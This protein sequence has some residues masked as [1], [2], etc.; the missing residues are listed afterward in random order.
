MKIVKGIFV[1]TMIALGIVVLLSLIL[2][3][4]MFMFPKFK[5][6]GYGFVYQ[7]QATTQYA[8]DTTTSGAYNLRKY[9]D[10]DKIEINVTCDTG[11]GVTIQPVESYDGNLKIVRTDDYYG[12][13]KGETNKPTVTISEPQKTG[14]VLTLDIA[15][16]TPNGGIIYNENCGITIY[17]PVFSTT[18]T[19]ECNNDTAYTYNLDLQT[20]TGNII[21]R[22]ANLNELTTYFYPLK[23]DSLNLSSTKGDITVSGITK[24]ITYSPIES[25]RKTGTNEVTLS[26][27]DVNTKGGNVYFTDVPKLI[28]QNGISLTTNNGD[29]NFADLEVT[30][31]DFSLTN[32]N[33]DIGLVANNITICNGSFEYKSESGL[34]KITGTLTLGIADEECSIYTSTA[35][36]KIG[37]VTGGVL[38][39]LNEYGVVEITTD[40][41]ASTKIDSTHGNVSVASC[42]NA[43]TII[44]D[45]ADINATYSSSAVVQTNRG[46]VTLT[47]N[48]TAGTDGTD[49]TINGKTVVSSV[50]GDINLT[51]LNNPFQ[52]TTTGSSNVTIN[53]KAVSV[54][55]ASS[56]TSSVNLRSGKLTFKVAESITYQYALLATGTISGN[57]GATTNF[58]SGVTKIMNNTDEEKYEIFNLTASKIVFANI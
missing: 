34:F 14:S 52:I 30:S 2:L 6:F 13:Y 43:L 21:L 45:M 22:N 11:Y 15:V 4:A 29:F 58:A 40:N 12:F 53:L 44:T 54:D 7:K 33:A 10:V 48:G 8:L 42:S 50:K 55:P 24:E 23:V 51:T 25:A 5:L 32:Q 20:T 28:I 49:H 39:I 27:F 36:I 17:V 41:A 31:G 19:S 46:K 47:S 56:V 57:I 35:P 1:Y 16:G 18:D 26:N 9:S 38:D 3:G 37:T